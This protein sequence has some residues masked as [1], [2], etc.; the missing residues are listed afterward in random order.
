MLL[1]NHAGNDES[2]G[3]RRIVSLHASAVHLSQLFALLVV[4]LSQKQ[5]VK[6]MLTFS[7]PELLRRHDEFTISAYEVRTIT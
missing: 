6:N 2:R 1:A 5:K 7:D 4:I 3:T